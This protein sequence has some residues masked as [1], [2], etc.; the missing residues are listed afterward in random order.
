MQSWQRARQQLLLL[1][2]L[3]LLQGLQQAQA[4]RRQRPACSA[5]QPL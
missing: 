3:L 5:W 2:L 1:L 4:G